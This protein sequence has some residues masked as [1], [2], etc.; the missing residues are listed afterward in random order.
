MAFQQ[1]RNSTDYAATAFGSSQPLT[2][3]NR[4]NVWREDDS[5]YGGGDQRSY[6][7]QQVQPDWHPAPNSPPPRQYGMRIRGAAGLEHDVHFPG[8]AEHG[9]HYQYRNQSRMIPPRCSARARSSPNGD[10]HDLNTLLGDRSLIVQRKDE[11][12]TE[13]QK[14]IN[15]LTSENQ[16]LAASLEDLTM[17]KDNLTRQ[18][19]EKNFELKRVHCHDPEA[20]HLRC[21]LTAGRNGKLRDADRYIKDLLNQIHNLGELPVPPPHEGF[22]PPYS[23]K[24]PQG[25][26]QADGYVGSDTDLDAR[27]F[28][29]DPDFQ[30]ADLATPVERRIQALGATMD[31]NDLLK[32]HRPVIVSKSPKLQRQ[33]KE[34]MV[35]A[36]RSDRT[37]GQG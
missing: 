26:R 2:R 8:A 13:Q 17:L 21:E 16:T 32:A 3:D 25:D 27:D 1:G 37:L 9:E 14:F 30:G 15:K 5:Y 4:T 34:S 10:H 6:H 23:I 20:L 31:E 19:H 36:G 22:R 29:D 11:Q 33:R 7:G 24:G 28:P 35:A 12:I 18:L